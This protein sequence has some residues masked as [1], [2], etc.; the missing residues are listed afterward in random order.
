MG[1][2]RGIL[3]L[4]TTAHI[5]ALLGQDFDAEATDSGDLWRTAGD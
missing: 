2:L 3:G 5:S 1:L 4:L